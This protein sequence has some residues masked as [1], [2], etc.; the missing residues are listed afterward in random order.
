MLFTSPSYSHFRG[1]EKFIR[2]HEPPDAPR[3]Q[4]KMEM[5]RNGSSPRRRRRRSEA[6]RRS[7]PSIFIALSLNFYLLN[8]WNN[9]HSSVFWRSAGGSTQFR[10]NKHKLKHNEERRRNQR[11]RRFSKEEK[12]ETVLSLFFLRQ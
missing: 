9:L 6:D 2:R 10:E 11:E 3:S 1:L 7:E 5:M 4:M 8:L 12:K